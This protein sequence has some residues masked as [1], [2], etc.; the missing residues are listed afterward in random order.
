[1][2]WEHEN[3]YCNICFDF[4][5]NDYGIFDGESIVPLLR[6]FNIEF[7]NHKSETECKNKF[8]DFLSKCHD[9]G[10]IKHIM[11]PENLNADE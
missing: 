7:K 8:F 1:M 5:W 3:E 6:G 10:L 9:E 2:C 11:V 4:L